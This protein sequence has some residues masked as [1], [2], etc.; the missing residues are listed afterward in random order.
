[1]LKL[2]MEFLNCNEMEINDFQMYFGP[3]LCNH[4]HNVSENLVLL[5]LMIKCCFLP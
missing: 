3:V 5:P 4:K 1:M 2:G